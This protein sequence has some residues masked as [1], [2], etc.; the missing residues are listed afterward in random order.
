MEITIER[1]AVR[2]GF[3]FQ[4]TFLFRFQ[5]VP[6]FQS[7]SDFFKMS[8]AIKSQAARAVGLISHSVLPRIEEGSCAN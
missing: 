2:K 5:S 7:V 1:A 4:F 8:K 6:S 3:Y